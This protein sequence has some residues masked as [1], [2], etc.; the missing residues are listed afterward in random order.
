[1]MIRALRNLA[2][3]TVGF[4][5]S[6][7]FLLGTTQVHAAPTRATLTAAVHKMHE[8]G[9]SCS[10]VM[11]APERA[12]TAAHCLNMTAPVVTIDGHDYPVLEAYAATPRDMAILIIPGAP[13]PCAVVSDTPVSEGDW[14]AAVGYP[15]GIIRTVTYGEVQGRIVYEEDG[16]EYLFVT[17]LG[18]PGNSGGGLF[19]E[20]GELVGITVKGAQG[21][22]M[23]ALEIVSIPLTDAIKYP[24]AG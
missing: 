14:V 7:S 24:R 19:N 8:P 23:L 17:T 9:T 2:Y 21:H 18:A 1:M 5:L 22:P 12:L 4:F 3:F 6:A 16:Q 13:C 20:R 11:I 10:A 15:W